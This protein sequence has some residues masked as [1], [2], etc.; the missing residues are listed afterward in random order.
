M[1]TAIS[2]LVIS[3]SLIAFSTMQD[4][5]SIIGAVYSAMFFVS[6]SIFAVGG[7]IIGDFSQLL[8]SKKP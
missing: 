4:K 2:M 3:A 6:V 8:K 5:T 7:V 1:K